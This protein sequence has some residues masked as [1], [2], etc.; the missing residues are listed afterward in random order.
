MKAIIKI[1]MY[2]HG[3]VV[4]WKKKY[5]DHLPDVLNELKRYFNNITPEMID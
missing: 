5:F 1:K 4:K 3:A 2:K